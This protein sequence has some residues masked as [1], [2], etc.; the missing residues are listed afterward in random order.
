V[1]QTEKKSIFA[2]FSTSKETGEAKEM[3]FMDHL[4]ALRWHIVRSLI[5][6]IVGSIVLFIYHDWVFDNVIIAPSNQNFISYKAFCNFGHFLRLGNSLCMP[7]VEIPF[8]GNTV[9]AAFSVALN[10]SLMGGFMIAFPYIFFELWKFVKPALSDK[11]LKY[12]RKSVFWVSFCFF[13]G[14]SFG[15][16]LLA[17]FTFNFLANFTIGTTGAYKYLPTLDD[18]IDTLTNLLLG[19]GIAFELPILAIVLAKIGLI[20]ATFLKNYRKYAYIIIL[21]LAAVITPSPDW[22]SQMIVALPLLT[23]FEISIMLVKKID[24]AKKIEEEKWE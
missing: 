2:R 22:I 1:L 24:K 16:Y 3:T 8:Q 12:G 11:E 17:P 10:I 5:V 6:W 14:C 13:L 15:Y 21:V 4:E 9:G 18:Y 19:C 7:P 23:L 20:N